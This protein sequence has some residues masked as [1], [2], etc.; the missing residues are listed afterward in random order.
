VDRFTSRQ[1]IIIHVHRVL[2]HFLRHSVVE[3]NDTRIIASAAAGLKY[4]TD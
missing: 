3:S 4:D 2:G 1:K